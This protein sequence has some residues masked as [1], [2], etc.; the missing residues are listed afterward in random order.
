LANVVLEEPMSRN[1][2]SEIHLHLTWHTKDS[3]PLL[4]PDTEPLAHR[5]I[6]QRIIHTPGA[7]VHEIGG[8]ETH[9]HVAVTI[10]PTLLISDFIG[11]LKGSS[12]HEVNEQLAMRGK[13]LQWQTGY[14]VVSFG[15]KQLPWV[16]DYIRNQREHHHLGTIRDR[17]ERV[18]QSD[19]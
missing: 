11:Q 15:A 7:R 19:A 17:L 6:K 10:P 8:T 18:T 14:G 3:L 9:V 12:S 5:Y 1:Y 2:Y 16:T 4:T 13:V